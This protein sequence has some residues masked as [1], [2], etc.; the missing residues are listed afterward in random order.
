MLVYRPD[1]TD[2]I[3]EE[4]SL[5]PLSIDDR[6]C[7]DEVDHSLFREFIGSELDIDITELLLIVMISEY[8][9][10]HSTYILFVI[11]DSDFYFI[12]SCEDR[13]HNKIFR[14]LF[15]EIGIE[16]VDRLLEF[17]PIVPVESDG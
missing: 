17:S 1:T 13:V 11:I 14:E 5:D 16:D 15:L 10:H 6:K 7:S 8:T 3:F 4:D 9:I 2:D 12:T